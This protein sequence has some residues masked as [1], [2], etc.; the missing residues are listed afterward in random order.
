MSGD[1]SVLVLDSTRRRPSARGEHRSYRPICG[2]LEQ[3]YGAQIKQLVTSFAA[4]IQYHPVAILN[5]SFTDNTYSTRAANAAA[6]VANY[7]P[8]AFATFHTLMYDPAVQPKKGTEGLSDDRLIALVK[9]A[10]VTNL[11]QIEQAIRH[12]TFKNW[13]GQRTDEFTSDAGP[14][15]NI[16]FS[17]RL[18]S[19]G[20]K[21]GPGTPELIVNG[22][23]WDGKT[24]FGAFIITVSQP[25]PDPIT[26]ELTTEYLPTRGARSPSQLG[27]CATSQKPDAE[28]TS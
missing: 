2:Q 25:D 11:P 18:D 20:R 15:R 23:Y 12:Q 7:S 16:D 3:Q 9:Q 8:S 22:Q 13:V 6:A 14:L 4:V 26:G 17:K 27:P 1:T 19:S 5:H 21:T 24:D 28:T 10:K